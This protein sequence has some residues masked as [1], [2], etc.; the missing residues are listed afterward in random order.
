MSHFL[1]G[2]FKS[3][4]KVRDEIKSFNNDE[5]FFCFNKS[6]DFFDDIFKMVKDHSILYPYVNVFC[7]TSIRQQ[8]NSEDILFPDD[9]YDIRKVINEYGRKEFENL[10][11]EN[12]KL[13]QEE[14]ELFIEEYHPKNLRIYV[15]DAY[16]IDFVVTKCT[17][18]EMIN[19]ILYQVID[20]FFLDSKIYEIV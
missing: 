19:D 15:S 2:E 17:L 20:D 3:Q 7:I 16:D 14:L 9:K 4:N 10:C 11:S 6:I 13:L 1:Y 12:L 18:E 5:I 8:C